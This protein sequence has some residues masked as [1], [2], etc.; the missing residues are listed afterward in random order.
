M[1]AV[2]GSRRTVARWLGFD[3][4][5]IERIEFVPPTVTVA[6]A[7]LT[8]DEAAARAG[9]RPLIAPE[10]GDPISIEAPLGRYVIVQ[11]DEAAVATL[12]GTLDEGSFGKLLDAGAEVTT[13]DVAGVPAYWITGG[14][15]FFLYVDD[16][17]QMQEARPSAD[18]LVWQRGDTI[19][20][21]EGDITLERATEIAESLREP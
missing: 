16:E 6:P 15:H 19:I 18:T 9:V 11:Y 21:V 1:L 7:G 2:P 17:G 20:R 8:L 14:P 3:E 5:R 10:L 13:L 12:P 4:L